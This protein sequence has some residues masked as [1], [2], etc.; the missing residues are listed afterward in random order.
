MEGN[1]TY[2]E[3]IG[4]NVKKETD[5]SLKLLAVIQDCGKS[6]LVRDMIE[7]Y[8]QER[9]WDIPALINN[10]SLHLFSRW[11][12][13]YGDKKSLEEYLES[14]EVNLT[15]RIKLPDYLVTEILKKCRELKEENPFNPK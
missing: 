2:S 10:L 12:M 14:V 7:A 1:Q 5:D 9:K 3:F 8:L 15:Q 11:H 6:T 4:L 13:R